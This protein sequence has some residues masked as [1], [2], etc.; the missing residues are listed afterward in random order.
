MDQVRSLPFGRVQDVAGVWFSL[1]LVASIDIWLIIKRGWL[2]HNCTRW[3]I[4]F[5]ICKLILFLF[6]WTLLAK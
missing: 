2:G 1:F 6:S 5:A 4:H 3:P